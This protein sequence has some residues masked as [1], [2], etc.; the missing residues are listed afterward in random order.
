MEENIASPSNKVNTKR[1]V[2]DG[3][4]FLPKGQEASVRG[5][6][7]AGHN[8]GLVI[9]T[10]TGL[11]KE[12]VLQNAFNKRGMP[13]SAQTAASK[14]GYFTSIILRACTKLPAVSL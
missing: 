6:N 1:D 13:S 12:L 2:P 8:A 14:R 10:R 3:S 5:G 7:G 11:R 4:C 9:P